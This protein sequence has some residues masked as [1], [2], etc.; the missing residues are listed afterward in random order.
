MNPH[1]NIA[2]ESMSLYLFD[3]GLYIKFVEGR[4]VVVAEVFCWGYEI[5]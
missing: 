1:L 5:F 3:K 2:K 4:G